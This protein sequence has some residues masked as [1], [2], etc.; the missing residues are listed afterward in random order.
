MPLYS[1]V[2]Q[3]GL[4]LNPSLIVLDECIEARRRVQV[5]VMCVTL[6]AS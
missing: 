2:R 1:I 4:R 6:C 3:V 5:Q